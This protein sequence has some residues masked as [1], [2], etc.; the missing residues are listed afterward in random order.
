MKK[1]LAFLTCGAL[2][3]EVRFLIRARGWE[4]D[5]Y[6]VPALHHLVPKLIVSTVRARLESLRDQYE[7]FIVV[8]GDCGT[9]GALDEALQGFPAVRPAGPHCYQMFAGQ[10]FD[11]ILDER[12]GTFFLTDWLI[13]AFERAV[14]EALGLD[15][16][17][18]LHEMYF[19]N[20]THLL[21]LQQFSDGGLEEG[22]R[23][24]ATYLGLPLEIRHVGLG[25]LERRLIELVEQPAEVRSAAG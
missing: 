3:R 9:A 8:Y 6:P 11:R 23:R 20:Y 22:A 25:D 2:R 21:Y 17:P 19:G 7:R 10:D 13:R 1:P 4:A 15:R 16:Y 14:V 5:V 12:P 18:E 24:I